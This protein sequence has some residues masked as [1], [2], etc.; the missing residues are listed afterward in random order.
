[1]T[2][3][4]AAD[5]MDGIYRHQRHIYDATRKF[6]LLGRDRL[7]RDLDPPPGGTVLEIGCG[8][9][10]NLIAAAR[11]HPDCALCGVDISTEMLR[12]ARAQVDRAGLRWRVL[13]AQGDAA[14]FEPRDHFGIVR[15]DRVFVS[16]SLSMIPVWDDVL[17]RAALLVAPGGRL[18]VVDFGMQERLP[19]VFHD[20]L[21][22]WLRRFHVTPRPDLETVMAAVAS[23]TGGSL[24]F[25]SLYGDYTR[26]GII[27]QPVA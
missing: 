25:H 10:R 7:I 27:S 1:M 20:G 18:H 26:Y 14:D 6:Y 16:Y 23:K 24:A 3:A 17:A 9:G 4:A 5:L 15:F 11:R 21:A 19:T 22:A 2:A 8:T 12:S 13:L